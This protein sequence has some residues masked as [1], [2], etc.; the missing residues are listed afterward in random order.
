MG[1]QSPFNTNSSNSH[2]VDKMLGNAYPVVREVYGK[3]GEIAYLVKNTEAILEAGNTALNTIEAVAASVSTLNVIEPRIESAEQAFATLALPLGSASVGHTSIGSGT[4]STTVRTK[5]SELVSVADFGAVGNGVTDDTE[6][7]LKATLYGVSLGLPVSFSGTKTYLIGAAQTTFPTGTRWITNGATFKIGTTDSGNST[8]FIYGENTKIDSLNVTVPAGIRKDRV[9][10]FTG[11]NIYVD[12]INIVSIDVQQ[13]TE[14][15]DGAVRF[16]NSTIVDIGTLSSLNYDRAVNVISCANV[17]IRNLNITGYV[18]GIWI[19]DTKHISVA[20]KITTGSVNAA[21]SAG[22]NA[23]LVDATSK[24][25]T[26]DVILNSLYVEGAGEHGIRVGGAFTCREIK[27]LNASVHNTGGCGIKM[28][29]GGVGQYHEDINIDGPTITD[30][31]Q[32]NFN[33]SGILLQYVLRCQIQSPTIHKRT[34]TYSCWHGINMGAVDTIQ[35][36]NPIIQ[37]T[38]NAGI[39]IDNGYG[40]S[41]DY[42]AINKGRLAGTLLAGS[43]GIYLDTTAETTRKL[44]I[45]GT[46]IDS[47]ETG[48]LINA[49]GTINRARIAVELWA[50]TKAVNFSGASTSQLII[51]IHGQGRAGST[52]NCQNGSTWNNYDTFAFE[53]LKAGVWTAM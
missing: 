38:A 23:V 1:I 2:I 42:I 4:I 28:L 19:S 21:Y 52:V 49:A 30:C 32:L 27:I 34:K 17:H 48:F 5:L 13:T 29:G 25:G 39:W 50:N 10:M 53:V 24:N 40:G 8:L 22:H 43:Y 18:R 15:N 36:D 3:L 26:E 35:I 41:N 45:I 37:A 16:Q 9:L 12:A 14:S 11:N 20:G 46:Q 6:A 31:G 51:D 44:S 47:F 7:I 33:T